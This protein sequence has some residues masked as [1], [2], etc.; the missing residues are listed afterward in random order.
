MYSRRTGTVPPIVK[1]D[2][3]SLGIFHGGATW[4]VMLRKAA[5][6]AAREAYTG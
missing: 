5:L 3:I 2:T 4:S 6:Q 1:P